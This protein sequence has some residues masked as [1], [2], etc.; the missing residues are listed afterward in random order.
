MNAIEIK[1]ACPMHPE[2]Q[3]KLNGK[4]SKCGMFLTIPVPEHGEKSEDKNIELYS[5]IQKLYVIDR[6]QISQI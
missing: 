2:I 6:N 4:C 1:Y 3:G 5:F